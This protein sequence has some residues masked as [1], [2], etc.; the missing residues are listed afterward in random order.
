MYGKL[1]TAFS[2]Q[3]DLK[4]ISHIEIF[5]LD[6]EPKRYDLEDIR[7]IS[8]VPE[9]KELDR[10]LLLQLG[11]MCDYHETKSFTKEHVRNWIKKNLK[12]PISYELINY[13]LKQSDIII[14]KDE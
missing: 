9:D 3:V 14:L 12:V 13:L 10:V 6:G 8:V 11:N 2:A 5:N 7:A 4:S 1:K